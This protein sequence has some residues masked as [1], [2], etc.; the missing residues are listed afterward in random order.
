MSIVFDPNTSNRSVKHNITSIRSDVSLTPD[1]IDL[2]PEQQE[3][4]ESLEDEIKK[5]PIREVKEVKHAQ[6]LPINSARRDEV[7]DIVKKNPETSAVKL[8]RLQLDWDNLVVVYGVKKPDNFSSLSI[9]E[10]EETYNIAKFNAEKFDKTKEY[11]RIQTFIYYAIFI[12]AKLCNMDISEDFVKTQVMVM[13]SHK[14]LYSKLPELSVTRVL[15]DMNPF[16]Q[17]LSIS[18]V[19]VVLYFIVNKFIGGD[20]ARSVCINLFANQS[21]L[22]SNVDLPWFGAIKSFASTFGSDDNFGPV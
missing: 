8:Y 1:P 16:Y 14:H 12:G 10:L 15:G 18:T 21:Q 6:Y 4:I 13:S 17:I 2:T 3:V 7:V 11:I 22:D 5:I 19:N 9:D 20:T